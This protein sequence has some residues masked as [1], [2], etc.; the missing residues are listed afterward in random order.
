MPRPPGAEKGRARGY[1]ETRAN[2]SLRVSVYQNSSYAF[3]AGGALSTADD[4]ATWIKALVGGKVFGADLQRQWL[5]SPQPAD[6]ADLAATQYGY[7][8]ERQTFA[9]GATMYF[10]FGELPGFNSFAGYDPVNKVTLVIWS[11]LTVSPDSRPTANALLVKVLGQIYTLPSAP[12]G[13][14]TG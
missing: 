13:E 4:L 9:P 6:P 5:D 7:G 10:H 8:I 12:S 2:G 3:A 14:E 1:I 11:N